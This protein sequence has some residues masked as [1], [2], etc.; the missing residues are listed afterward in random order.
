MSSA[1]NVLWLRGQMYVEMKISNRRWRICVKIMNAFRGRVTFGNPCHK[2][3]PRHWANHQ[4][5][6]TD[7]DWN[8]TKETTL[9]ITKI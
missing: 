5:M 8:R 6:Y 1:L 4:R 7:L 9:K 3:S 2:R